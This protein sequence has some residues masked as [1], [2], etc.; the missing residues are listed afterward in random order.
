MGADPQQVSEGRGIGWE[1]L[2]HGGRSVHA[3]TAWPAQASCLHWFVRSF[4]ELKSVHFELDDLQL[5]CKSLLTAVLSSTHDLEAQ[6]RLC[7]SRI[8]LGW[9]EQESVSAPT[10]GPCTTHSIASQG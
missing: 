2:R 1:G 10:V 8:L 7:A 4:L 5:L 3:A 9:N 6:V